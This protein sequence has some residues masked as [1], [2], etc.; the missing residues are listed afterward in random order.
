M[1][2]SV[3]K[4]KNDADSSD[5]PEE[6]LDEFVFSSGSHQFSKEKEKNKVKIPILLKKYKLDLK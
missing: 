4:K 1:I 5:Y 3:D 2:H 6:D